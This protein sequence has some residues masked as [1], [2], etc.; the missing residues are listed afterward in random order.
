MTKT[1]DFQ[2]E[3]VALKTYIDGPVAVI[4]LKCNV[5]DTITDLTE[6]GKFI[7]FFHMSERNPDIKALLILNDSNCLNEEEYDHFLRRAMDE[8]RIAGSTE[9]NPM[10]EKSFRTRQVNILNRII[11]Q[12]VDFKKI[13]VVALQQHVVTPFF[14]ASL[15]ADFRF[16]C[17]D[18]VFSLA[19]MKYGIHP[20]GAL[21]F[22]LPQFVPYS[23]AIDILFK[24][25][26]ITAKEALHLGLVS[27][28][29]PGENFSQRCIEEIKRLAEMNPRVIHTTKLLLNLGRGNIRHYLD[30]ESALLH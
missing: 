20:G 17:E 2:Y 16:A 10:F 3:D 22:F 6:S 13:S 30:T 7:S 11:L 9:E 15:A 5:F 29:F 18:M 14:G 26:S 4:E 24:G 28:I 19:H 12:L 8:N 27:E 21:P 23:Q 25:K 1:I